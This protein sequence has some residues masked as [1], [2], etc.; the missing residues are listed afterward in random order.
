[1][2]GQV[3]GTQTVVSPA[4]FTP[5][6]RRKT[7]HVSGASSAFFISIQLTMEEGATEFGTWGLFC[8]ER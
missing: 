1:M 5:R 3:V 4:I 2:K 7:N 8:S 6:G